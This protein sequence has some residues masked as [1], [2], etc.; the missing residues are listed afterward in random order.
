MS[1]PVL[2]ISFLE[3]SQS[4]ALGIDGGVLVLAAPA[5]SPAAAA[6]LVGTSRSPDGALT[7][8]DV[9]VEIDGAPIAT[10]ADMFKALDKR[11]PGDVCRVVVARGRRVSADG[12]ADDVVTARVPLDVTLGAADDLRVPPPMSGRR[13]D[14]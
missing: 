3:A 13:S 12:G 5:D 14:R 9:V 11:R 6:G 2:G 8:G 4:R 10:E 7:L 1:R